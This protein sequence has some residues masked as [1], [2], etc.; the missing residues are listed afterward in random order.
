MG[1]GRV[2]NLVWSGG[3]WLGVC[4]LVLGVSWMAKDFIVGDEPEPGSVPGDADRSQ[5][6]RSWQDCGSPVPALAVSPG[7]PY[8]GWATIGGDVW[9]SE[10]SSSRSF[11]LGR[12]S[13]GSARSVSIAPD[14]RVLAVAGSGASV[15]LWDMDEGRMLDKLEIDRDVAK[16]V[17]FAPT[18]RLLAV[19]EWSNRG[20]G[21]VSLWDWRDRRRCR[22]LDGHPGGIN[23]LAFSRDAALLA[24]CDS[25][26]FVKVWDVADGRERARWPASRG[27]TAVVA[28]A[29]S[30]DGTRL[31]T[32][33]LF[34]SVVRL[35]DATSG[36]PCGSVAG[37]ESSV[38][39]L[40]FS[41]DG[42][43]LAVARQ[44]GTVEI[45]DASGARELGSIGPR[46]S[47]LQAVIF[48]P[49]GRTLAT[50]GADGCLRLW[51]M[52]EALAG[53]AGGACEEIGLKIPN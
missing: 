7:G 33:A 37:R 49:D 13:M 32:A 41:P 10:L 18:G 1:R 36:R 34:D 16:T 47:A 22:V 14:G 51:D 30:P 2:G 20:F 15:R 25:A 39:G 45:R 50:G 8:L 17:A 4:F 35:W 6:Q 28:L 21:A 11:R 52:A 19:G 3:T 24:S 38:N 40:T 46:S 31:A 23:A 12:G 27:G 9:M 48:A 42:K 5:A 53:R 44:D 43:L 26:G 29:L